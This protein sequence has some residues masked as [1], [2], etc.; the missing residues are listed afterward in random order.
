MRGAHG[1]LQPSR[2]A[3]AG[4]GLGGGG[5]EGGVTRTRAEAWRALEGFREAWGS[6]YPGVVAGWWE[7]SG[8]LLRF[9]EYPEVLWPCLRSE[10]RP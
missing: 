3:G 4:Q 2:G 9:Y 6:R 7:N 10:P 8:S 5:F 1:A